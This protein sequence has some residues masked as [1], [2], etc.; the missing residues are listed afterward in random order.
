MSRY[1]L[2]MNRYGLYNSVTISRALY[3]QRHQTFFDILVTK[4]SYNQIF[5]IPEECSN[6][7][8]YVDYDVCGTITKE[9]CAVTGSEE[10]DYDVGIFK[11]FCPETCGVCSKYI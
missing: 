10:Y 2:G 9:D 6:K 7:E 4:I 1:E 8:Q 3:I 11:E 5:Y